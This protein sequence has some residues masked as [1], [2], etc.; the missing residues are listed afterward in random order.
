M[1]LDTDEI[2]PPPKP[3]AAP[4][5]LSKLSLDELEARIAQLE[6]EIA[7]CRDAIAV[8]KR[9]LNAAESVFRTR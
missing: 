8:K 7:R 2:A 1:A 5:D 4:A 3:A 9:S 6:S